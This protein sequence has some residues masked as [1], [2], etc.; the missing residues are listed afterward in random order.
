MHTTSS[1]YKCSRRSRSG[2][3]RHLQWLTLQW[4][5]PF[6]WFWLHMRPSPRES[7]MTSLVKASDTEVMQEDTM[8]PHYGHPP[9]AKQTFRS[10]ISATLPSGCLHTFLPTKFVAPE[11]W[12]PALRALWQ[13]TAVNC[14]VFHTDRYSVWSP[15]RQTMGF[16]GSAAASQGFT[17]WC[18]PSPWLTPGA[19]Y[20]NNGPRGWVS[21]PLIFR[22]EKTCFMIVLHILFEPV[23]AR[24]NIHVDAAKLKED[25]SNCLVAGPVNFS[26]WTSQTFL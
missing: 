18:V 6:V 21:N 4:L 24:K 23:P 15:N 11:R 22:C 8:G 13:T 3:K 25:I 2:A 12:I 1:L 16:D 5:Q 20:F 26:V 19:F 10:S 14:V 17:I 7:T 9:R